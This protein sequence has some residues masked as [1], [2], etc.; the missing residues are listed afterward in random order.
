MVLNGISPLTS[1]MSPMS[2]KTRA[3]SPL[4]SAG[5]STVV[6]L[7]PVDSIVSPSAA[8]ATTAGGGGGACG[9]RGG[10]AA[11]GTARRARGPVAPTPRGGPAAGRQLGGDH[12]IATGAL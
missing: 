10:G 8:A 7:G 5:G 4:V 1:S 9:G 3:R 11:G 2:W 6:I 12:P